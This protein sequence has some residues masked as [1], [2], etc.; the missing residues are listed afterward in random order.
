MIA[1]SVELLRYPIPV[2]HPM[3]TGQH[4]R[5]RFVRLAEPVNDLNLTL[6]DSPPLNPVRFDPGDQNLDNPSFELRWNWA[7]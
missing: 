3:G 1:N 5:R 7:F 2:A 6:L 4:Q